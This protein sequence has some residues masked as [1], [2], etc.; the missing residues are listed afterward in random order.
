MRPIPVDV[1]P[2]HI[3]LSQEDQAT[4]FGI[5]R[6]MTIFKE[7]SQAGQLVY[8]ETLEVQGGLKRVLQLRIMGPNWE[9]SQVY[10]TPTEAIYLGLKLQDESRAGD[11]S[12]AAACTLFGPKDKVFLKNGAIIP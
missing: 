12:Q 5:G 3:Y 8:E 11:L 4:L 6:P 1:I 9:Q 10:L 7:H 2:S